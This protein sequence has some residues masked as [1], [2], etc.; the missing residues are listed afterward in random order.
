MVHAILGVR[1]LPRRVLSLYA[2]LVSVSNVTAQTATQDPSALEQRLEHA[3]AL[4]SLTL[5]GT[6]P[7]HLKLNLVTT[8]G[9]SPAVQETIEEWW[10]AQ[11]R[12]HVEYTNAAGVVTSELHNSEGR[13]RTRDA[14]RV[15]NRDRQLLRDVVDPLPQN[16]DLD[17]VQLESR[18]VT[19]SNQSFDCIAVTTKLALKPG[20][21]DPET[22]YCFDTE[23]DQLRLIYPVT[24]RIIARAALGRFQG[25]DVPVKLEDRNAADRLTTVKLV[26]LKTEDVDPAK[27]IPDSN[28]ASAPERV[29]MPGGVIAGRM[30]GGQVPVY[31]EAATNSRI[32]GQVILSAVISKD[33]HVTDLEAESSPS[34]ILTQASINAV[35]TWTY[36]PALLGGTPVEVETTIIVNFN[37]S[38]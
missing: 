23:K 5:P 35:K 37:L 36:D 19:V 1:N 8:Q 25:R 18:S 16:F 22:R 34:S 33:G 14:P 3:A 29:S 17:R 31:P 27:F 38:Q 32:S 4:T 28:M 15:S 11:E 6:R 9:R 24:Y 2:I 13:Y 30:I 21:R 7:W 26:T 10:A 12:W 20:V